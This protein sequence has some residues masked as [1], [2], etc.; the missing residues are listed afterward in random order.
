M[1]VNFNETLNFRAAREED[2]ERH[3]C[4]MSLDAI[5]RCLTLWSNPGDV[6]FSPFAGVGSEGYQALMMGRK[7]VGIELKKSY[8]N[9]A[10]KNLN[11]AT[12]KKQQSLF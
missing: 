3:I 5:A 8:Y 11:S 1:D 2:D 9:Q 4:P 6:V 7:F 10:I 12:P